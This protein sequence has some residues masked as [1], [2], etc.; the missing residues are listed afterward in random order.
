MLV[1]IF[2][3]G[4][5]GLRCGVDLCR[6]GSVDLVW[7]WLWL[8]SGGFCICGRMSLL[9]CVLWQLATCLWFCLGLCDYGCLVSLWFLGLCGSCCGVLLGVCRLVG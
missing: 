9:V 3:F 1:E 8:L 7:V 6:F 2:G 5:V 4:I